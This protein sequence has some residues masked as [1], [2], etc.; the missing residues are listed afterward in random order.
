LDKLFS[1]NFGQIH[2][3]KLVTNQSVNILQKQALKD[4]L[5][6]FHK[7]LFKCKLIFHPESV[8][9]LNKV[10]KLCIKSTPEPGSGSGVPDRLRPVERVVLGPALVRA[11][12]IPTDLERFR[13][14]LQQRA[15]LLRHCAPGTNVVIRKIF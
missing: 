5:Q 15:Q 9:L 12:R 14:L 10:K 11:V 2:I 3:Y 13:P 4:T 8:L 1:Y 7:S 6:R